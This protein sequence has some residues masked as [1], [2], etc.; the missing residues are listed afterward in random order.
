[1]LRPLGDR[2]HWAH[3][4]SPTQLSPQDAGQRG[5]LADHQQPS[6]RLVS[7]TS[8]QEGLGTG[9]LMGVLV[10]NALRPVLPIGQGQAEFLQFWFGVG[11]HNS[12]RSMLFCLPLVAEI[13][14]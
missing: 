9:G 8:V 14:F 3:S 5:R 6:G 4:P 13:A 1:M 2:S 12:H 7:L 11:V 10:Q